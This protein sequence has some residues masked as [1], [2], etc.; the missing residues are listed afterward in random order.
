MVRGQT[1]RQNPQCPYCGLRY[2]AFRMSISIQDVY[3]LVRAEHENGERHHYTLR[4]VLGKAH[5][6]K[7]QEWK[8]HL[9]QCSFYA[10]RF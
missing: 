4:T 8:E 3:A 5:E 2:R 10:S 9:D 7:F 6:I 1:P